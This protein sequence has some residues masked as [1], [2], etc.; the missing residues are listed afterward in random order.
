MRR[1]RRLAAEALDRRFGP[2]NARLDAL[3][4][5]LDASEARLDGQTTHLCEHRAPRLTGDR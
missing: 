2:L 4:A 5:R 3:D 1:W